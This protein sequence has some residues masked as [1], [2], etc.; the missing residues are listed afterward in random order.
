MR[1]ISFVD[2]AVE[3]AKLWSMRSEDP[4]KKVGCCILNEN[5]RVLSV[6]YNGLPSKFN[7]KKAFWLNRDARRKFMIHAEVNALSLI[8]TSDKPYLLA[9]TLLPC[10]ACASSIISYGIKNVVYIEDCN[11]DSSSIEI[12]K[13][14]KINIS[15][16]ESL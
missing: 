14:F 15:K 1:R 5:G 4:Y 8:K 6:G 12:F 10:A 16:Y 2:A 11:Q 7:A 9:S 3:T 13:Y